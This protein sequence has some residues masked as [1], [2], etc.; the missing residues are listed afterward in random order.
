MSLSGKRYYRG[1]Q[2]TQPSLI[3]IKTVGIED[4][5]TTGS[6]FCAGAFRIG[7]QS[8]VHVACI[9]PIGPV[10]AIERAIVCM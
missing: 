10:S 5:L 8:G 2:E 9:G 3:W 1:L 7:L 4:D 6:D